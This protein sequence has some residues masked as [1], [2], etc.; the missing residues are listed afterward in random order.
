M[1]QLSN[2]SI[3]MI[4]GDSSLVPGLQLAVPSSSTKV[5]LAGRSTAA[6]TS[7]VLQLPWQVYPS[8][9]LPVRPSP[10]FDS[11]LVEAGPPPL[12]LRDGTLLFLYN[13]AR[14]GYPSPKPGYSLQYNVGWTRLNQTDLSVLERSEV[15][16]LSPTLPWETGNATRGSGAVLDLT[17]NVVFCNGLMR[18]PLQSAAPGA[19]PSMGSG[20]CTSTATVD[21]FLMFYGGADSVVGV[22]EISVTL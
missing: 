3:A 22:A 10:F 15:P 17:P 11:H 4:F 18:C 16:L 2:G 5:L 19:H 12:P 14:D 20:L 21:R 1:V 6:E 9:F 13:S 7:P 8:V